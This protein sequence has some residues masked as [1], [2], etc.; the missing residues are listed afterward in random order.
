ML[1]GLIA[2]VIFPIFKK[3]KNSSSGR[4]LG[5]LSYPIY[6]TH[7]LVITLCAVAVGGRDHLSGEFIIVVATAFSVLLYYFVEMPIDRWRQRFVASSYSA[8]ADR[9]GGSSSVPQ[10]LGFRPGE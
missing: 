2:V 3:S 9:Q 8:S 5:E 1:Y 4:I 10:P 7:G 6:I